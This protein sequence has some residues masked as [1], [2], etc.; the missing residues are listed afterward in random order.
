[1][2]V[3]PTK[4]KSKALVE[5]RREQIVLAAIKL[6]SRKGFHKTSLR[7]MAEEAGISHGNFY[8]YIRTKQDI[9]FLIH[10][11]I[12]NLALN[13]VNR[14]TENIED[15]AEKLRRMVRAE[16]KLMHDWSDAILLLYRETHVLDKPLLQSLLKR[17]SARVRKIEEVLQMGVERGRFRDV[18][19]RVAA[20]LIKSM[21]ETWVVKRWHLRGHVDRLEME[22]TILDLTFNG[23]V[24]GKNSHK[25]GQKEFDELEGKSVL[26]LNSDSL[27]GK[28]ISF[29]LLSNKVRL[30]I[31]TSEGLREYKEYPMAS[32]EKLQE[33]KIYRSERKSLLTKRLFREII[34]DFGHV[35]VVIH[36]LGSS[37]KE[38]LTHKDKRQRSG[39]KLQDNYHCAQDL[40]GA[41]EKEMRK[42]RSGKVLYLA[43]WAWDKYADPLRYRAIRAGTEA[44]TKG[45]AEKLADACVN[46]NSIMPGF[47]GGVRPLAM[48]ESLSSRATLEIPMGYLGE[49]SDVLNAVWYLI[50]DRSKYVTGQVLRVSGG[51]E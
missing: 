39:R 27:L 43:P 36:D 34:E 18:N 3:I 24:P 37:I 49:I 26:V 13:E 9:F 16:F 5:K 25:G 8:D 14:S 31:Q 41:V 22:R 1:M 48:E 17:E 4:V 46:V 47:I 44:L 30:A 45:L 23:L 15:P 32:P 19:T 20:D 42:R 35:D 40:A 12:N 10:E 38:M 2:Y 33:A 29:F 6:F 7:E 21:T 11:F 50:S 28:A 51:I